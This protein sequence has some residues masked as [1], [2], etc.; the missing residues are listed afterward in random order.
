M[1]DAIC[2]QLPEWFRADDFVPVPC[3][4]PTCRS[5]TFALYDGED[6]SRCRAW[7][8]SRTTSTTSPTAPCPTSRC[9]R[10]SRACG[11]PRRPAARSP[12]A[13]RLDCVACATGMPP[14]L[15]EVAARGFMVVVQD[16]QD[17]YTFDVEKSEVLRL[18]D[19]PRRSPD[20]VL[21]VQLG[22][23]PRAGATRARLG[24]RDRARL[25]RRGQRGERPSAA[26]GPAAARPRRPRL[27]GRAQGMLRR[28]LRA[29]G[30]PL[31]ARR[32]ART[33]AGRPR[34]CA[35][36][37]SAGVQTGDRLLDVAAGQGTSAL[38][39]ARELGC[40]VDGARVRGGGGG[41]PRMPPRRRR[42]AVSRIES[43]REGD[44]E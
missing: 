28:R 39:A 15:R 34:R 2:D 13:E 5:A 8:M 21:R 11:R 17:P 29:P 33:P 19:R 32:G 22:R 18:R 20:P 36:S 38:L 25:G 6:L 7:S 41:R 27:R 30:G 9:A 31:A 42:A 35:R 14:E 16:F 26:R 3:C 43:F 1:I 24:G 44:A 23:L 40:E 4:S 37:S 12:V 10:R